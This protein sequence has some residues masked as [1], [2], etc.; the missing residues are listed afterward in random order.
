MAAKMPP[1]LL[2][3]GG[4]DDAAGTEE[5]ALLLAASLSIAAGKPSFG[6]GR[7]PVDLS[8]LLRL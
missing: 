1:Y 7:Y 2:V 3:G 5:G 8:A 6:P 4:G